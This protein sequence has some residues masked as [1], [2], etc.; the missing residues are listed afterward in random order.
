MS[1]ICTAG[2]RRYSVRFPV[3]IDRR[4]DGTS[5]TGGNGNDA[6][7]R[8]GLHPNPSR[9]AVIGGELATFQPAL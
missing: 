3:G 9:D 4:T 8:L 1:L 7:G 2:L 6:S 5:K